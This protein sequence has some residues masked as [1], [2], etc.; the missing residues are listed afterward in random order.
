MIWHHAQCTIKTINDPCT[1]YDVR[2]VRISVLYIVH[3]AVVIMHI[4]KTVLNFSR[5]WLC[6][7][8]RILMKGNE[9]L[10]LCK[11]FYTFCDNLHLILNIYCPIFTLCFKYRLVGFDLIFWEN[12][13]KLTGTFGIGPVLG[14]WC[15]LVQVIIVTI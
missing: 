13:L 7:L 14:D 5:K 15:Q 4:Q 12:K 8:M 3:C 1:M 10:M 11:K 2:C 6:F 9:L